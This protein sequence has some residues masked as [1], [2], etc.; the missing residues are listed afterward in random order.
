MKKHLAQF[1]LYFLTA[2]FAFQTVDFLP[3]RHGVHAKTCCGRT[4]CQCKH[5]K[6][7]FCPMRAAMNAKHAHAQPD[8]SAHGA[9]KACHFSGGHAKA[10]Q[11][12]P[13]LPKGTCVFSSA[14]CATDTP[15]SL[16]P[17]YAKDF[18]V[19]LTVG[20]F[21]AANEEPVLLNSRFDLP[22]PRAQGIDHPP[23]SLSFS[24]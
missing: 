23:R 11:P 24:F 5:A 10:K 19:P 17:Q 18:F 20:N 14:P 2:V 8:V 7:A 12:I 3:A 16:L 4:V 1:T 13:A 15:Q 21:H 22:L 6:G 9:K